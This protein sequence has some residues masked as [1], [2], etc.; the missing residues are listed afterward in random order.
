MNFSEFVGSLF[1]F[2][3]KIKELE[4]A[5]DASASLTKNVKDAL[6]AC[7]QENSVKSSKI[8]ELT[9]K[10]YDLEKEYLPD[11]KETFWNNKYPKAD[12]TYRRKES[13]KWYNIDVRDYFQEFDSTIPMVSGRNIDEKALNALIYVHDHT[14]YA[15]DNEEYGFDEFWAYS[16]QTLS[17]KRGDCEDGSILL[18]NVLLRSGVP[19]WRIRLNVGEV[20]GGRHCYVTYCR[21]SDNQ[22]VVLDWCYSFNN[23]PVS[24]RLLHS[25]ER[26]YYGVEFSWNQ[27]YSFSI[28]SVKGFGVN[29]E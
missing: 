10:V 19:Y 22:F 26:N 11:P 17:H 9:G 8:E 25:E 6:V 7:E 1:G 14:K 20:K 24:D 12:I 16:Y 2:T 28:G 4:L 18:A 23:K 27:K 15:R 13:D 5:L 21:E 29:V 3:Q